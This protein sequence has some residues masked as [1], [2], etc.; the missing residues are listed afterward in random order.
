[1]IELI[2]GLVQGILAPIIVDL[3]KHRV[4][5]VP[6]KEIEVAIAAAARERQSLSPDEIAKVVAG[7]MTEILGVVNRDPDLTW[8]FH[9]LALSRPVNAK[10]EPLQKELISERLNR[11]Q[12]LIDD[13]REVLGLPTRALSSAPGIVWEQVV[14][15]EDVK[16]I[17]E[18]DRLRKR[19]NDRRAG[20]TA[21][22]SQA[23]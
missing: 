11:L 19:V 1:M 18:L 5:A 13:R 7:T 20:R 6:K 21:D 14:P 16:E 15:A 12:F 2:L 4:S 9:K 17:P 23:D 10:S 22:D 8:R 3:L